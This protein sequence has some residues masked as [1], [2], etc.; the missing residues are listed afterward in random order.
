MKF[1]NYTIMS[2]NECLKESFNYVRDI[3]SNNKIEVCVI[4]SES[5]IGADKIH[6]DYDGV[7]WFDAKDEIRKE[8]NYILTPAFLMLD[9]GDTV[10][11]AVWLLPGSQEE[12]KE[13][14][15]KFLR[16]LEK[17]NTSY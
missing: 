4:A 15:T 6:Y 7:I 10:R 3:K 8:V 9:S 17:L 1:T 12:N 11:L 5:N 16:E 14:F 13:E 2:K